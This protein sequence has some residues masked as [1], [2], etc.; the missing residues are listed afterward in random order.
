MKYIYQILSYFAVILVVIII[1][2][3]LNYARNIDYKNQIN[4]LHLQN[5][6]LKANID[7]NTV[8]INSLSSEIK[9]YK[10]K[11]EEDKKKLALLEVKAKKNKQKYNEESN[12]INSLSNA[13]VISE[14]TNAFQ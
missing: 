10:L 5:D 12:R 14:F 11:V 13:S 6:S 1:Y 3:N 2:N 9:E 7:S 8:I 4:Q